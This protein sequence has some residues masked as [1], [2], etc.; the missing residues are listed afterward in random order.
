[1]VGLLTLNG[2]GLD[3]TVTVESEA[4]TFSDVAA[5]RNNTVTYE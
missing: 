2:D 3:T 1:V 5:S 4:A